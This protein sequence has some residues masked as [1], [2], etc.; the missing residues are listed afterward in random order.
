M[1]MS[2]E[3]IRKQVL[4]LQEQIKTLEEQE[5]EERDALREKTKRRWRFLL[6][7]NDRAGWHRL[8]LGC[9]VKSYTLTGSVVNSEE[10]LAAGHYDQDVKGGG[11]DY[12]VNTLNGR[13]VASSGG[14]SVYIADALAVGSG[15]PGA[16]ECKEDAER[17]Y[18]GLEAAIAAGVEDVT[19]VILRQRHFVWK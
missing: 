5:R 17:V 9:G 4:H 13:I 8:R 18:A 2:V 11:M 10:C 16:L 6:Q 3:E 12:L 15:N 19:N 14:G 7:E 1:T